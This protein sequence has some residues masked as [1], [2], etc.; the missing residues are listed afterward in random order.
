MQCVCGLW[1]CSHV[2]RCGKGGGVWWGHAV[3][4]SVPS[5][6]A[7]FPQACAPGQN[8]GGGSCGLGGATAWQ[9]AGGRTH[10]DRDS[11]MEMINNVN[12]PMKASG[13]R[14]SSG[15]RA[16]LQSARPTA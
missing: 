15:T 7:S 10:R 16:C 3:F 13:H 5:S 2:G 14:S 4:S 11:G 1:Q 9:G 12:P 8:T 6:E